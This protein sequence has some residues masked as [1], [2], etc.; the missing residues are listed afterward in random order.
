MHL[1][2]MGTAGAGK[3][4]NKITGDNNYCILFV[5]S[6]H[7]RS[8]SMHEDKDRHL[9]NLAL[10]RSYQS[11][12]MVANM[13][14]KK[15]EEPEGKLVSALEVG[16]GV[17]K[18]VYGRTVGATGK[19]LSE[20]KGMMF[21]GA[22]CCKPGEPRYPRYN[23]CFSVKSVHEVVPLLSKPIDSF[24]SRCVIMGPDDGLIECICDI[25]E[26]KRYLKAQLKTL[27]QNPN[28]FNDPDSLSVNELNTEE[29]KKKQTQIRILEKKIKRINPHIDNMQMS[30]DSRVYGKTI[31]TY[32]YDCIKNVRAGEPNADS[33]YAEAFSNMLYFAVADGIGWG[34]PSRRA[35]QAALLGFMLAL[36]EFHSK[37]K[38]SPVDTVAMAQACFHGIEF[39]HQSVFSNTEAKTTFCGGI[40][41]ELEHQATAPQI[42]PFTDDLS[43]DSD[44]DSELDYDSDLKKKKRWVFVGVSVGDSLIYRYSA[45][46]MEVMELTV[47]DRTGGV[48]DAGGCLGG[49]EPDLRNMTY[50]YCL[51]EEGD[52]FIAVSDG[53]HDN[54]DPEVL[55]QSPRD[56]GYSGD[57]NTSWR[58]LDNDIKNELKRKFK[59]ERLLEII[60]AVDDGSPQTI[61]DAIIQEITE[62]T[63][64]QRE[65]YEEGSRLQRDW[66]KMEEKERNDLNQWVQTTLKTSKGKFDHVTCLTVQVGK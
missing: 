33:F 42:I 66:D 34:V 48:R 51:A 59:E 53:V 11:N 44:S 4:D 37:R 40:V 61:T 14:A 54:L 38:G 23:A 19:K 57:P 47:S 12:D 7:K 45:S 2:G 50:H 43:S 13:N 17:G 9:R 22:S 26:R 10:N 65:G 60:E 32:A 1:E 52:L 24:S 58:D 28:A 36:S 31:A 39:A 62:V 64:L 6:T 27:Q 55:K 49:K 8:S 3:D 18:G 35:S 20:I 15:K 56:S 25:G 16:K 30:N 5:M 29:I 41:V 21:G 46:T 63:R